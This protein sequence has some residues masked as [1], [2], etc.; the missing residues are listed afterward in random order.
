M[1]AANAKVNILDMFLIV[2]FL[3]IYMS[4]EREVLWN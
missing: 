3:K 2:H 4:E 1:Y